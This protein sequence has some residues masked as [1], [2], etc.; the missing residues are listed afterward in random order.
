VDEGDDNG[1]YGDK[2]HPSRSV[3]TLMARTRRMVERVNSRVLGDAKKKFRFWCERT[4]RLSM[5]AVSSLG[6]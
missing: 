1:F 2:P 4:F 5:L 3:S 6:R